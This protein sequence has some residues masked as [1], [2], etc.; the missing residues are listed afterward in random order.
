MPEVTIVREEII[1]V[2]HATP[3]SYGN[4]MVTDKTGREHRVNQKHSSLHPIFQPDMAVKVGYGNFMNKE[5]IHTAI[6]V[7]DNLPPPVKPTILPEHQEVIDKVKEAVKPQPSGQ[8][9][10]LFW[11]ELGEWLRMKEQEKGA[12]PFWKALRK[13]YFAQMFSVLSIKVSDKTGE[14]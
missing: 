14:E 9:V 8:E 3:D 7:K 10:G 2:D 12:D 1:V 4:L 5:F 11:K 13:L 6:Q